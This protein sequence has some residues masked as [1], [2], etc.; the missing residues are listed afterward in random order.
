LPGTYF[1]TLDRMRLVSSPSS[2]GW[3][4]PLTEWSLPWSREESLLH[5]K[6]QE[7]NAKMLNFEW[8][9]GVQKDYSRL[10]TLCCK[11]K[12]VDL[13]VTEFT[14][15]QEPFCN[16]PWHVLAWK[17]HPSEKFSKKITHIQDWKQNTECLPACTHYINLLFQNSNKKA[18]KLSH[19]EWRASII[20]L[21]TKFKGELAG[22][23]IF[24][25]QHKVKKTQIFFSSW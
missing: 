6:Y 18:H 9:K 16:F 14:G 4:I 5:L 2:N 8:Q 25:I 21:N 17:F 22:I 11:E 7:L 19:V 3:N 24:F 13:K 23:I 1:L 10:K 20:Q 15:V 12:V